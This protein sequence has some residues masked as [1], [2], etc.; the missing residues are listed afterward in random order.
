MRSESLEN[1]DDSFFSFNLITRRWRIFLLFSIH[2]FRHIGL[3]SLVVVNN[4]KK[5]MK[6]KLIRSSKKKGDRKIRAFPFFTPSRDWMATSEAENI[7]FIVF[8]L[9]LLFIMGLWKFQKCFLWDVQKKFLWLFEF[10]FSIFTSI[11]SRT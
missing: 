1:I 9:Y 11:R 10:P 3:S 6:E 5:I 8:C 2:Y 4:R 7:S